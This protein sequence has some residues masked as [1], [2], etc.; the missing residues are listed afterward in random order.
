MHTGPLLLAIILG[1]RLTITVTDAVATHPLISVPVTVY[2][3]VIIG[4]ATTLTPIDELSPVEG[5]QE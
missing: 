5:F 4:C 3:V 2:V 1:G